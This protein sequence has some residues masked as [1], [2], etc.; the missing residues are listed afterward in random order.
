[1]SVS[2]VQYHL[3]PLAMGKWGLLY[4]LG[5]AAVAAAGMVARAAVAAAQ[6]Y[7]DAASLMAPTFSFTSLPP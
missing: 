4:F 6:G 7:A 2:T 3:G 5:A 1:M